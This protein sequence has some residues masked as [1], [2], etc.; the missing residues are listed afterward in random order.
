MSQDCHRT[1]HGGRAGLEISHYGWQARSDATAYSIDYQYYK[2]SSFVTDDGIDRGVDRP[3]WSGHWALNAVGFAG[4][5]EGVTDSFLPGE[6]GAGGVVGGPGFG[7]G[8]G[9]N[10]AGLRPPFRRFVHHAPPWARGSA[11]LWR[12]AFHSME[13]TRSQFLPADAL[14][15]DRTEM[16]SLKMTMEGRTFDS[17]KKT[18][19]PLADA[20][21]RSEPQ[22]CARR[23]PRAL[24]SL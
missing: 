1:G 18:E 22:R 11:H 6:V 7:G 8:F 10:F 14:A 23:E 5:E 19:P 24:P 9:R 12:A 20:W 21:Q 16:D 17:Q 15:V 13:S 2:P 4:Q 3:I